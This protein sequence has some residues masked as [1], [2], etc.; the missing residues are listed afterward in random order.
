[1]IPIPEIGSDG[2]TSRIWVRD[3]LRWG[4]RWGLVTGAVIA[5]AALGI[6]GLKGFPDLGFPIPALIG[7]YLLAGGVGGM[8]VGLTRH[9]MTTPTR[10]SLLGVVI[11]VPV[12]MLLAPAALG[13]YAS[14]NG[15]EF[16]GILLSS[17]FLGWFGSRSWW[18]I[19]LG[20]S[21]PQAPTSVPVPPRRG[22]NRPRGR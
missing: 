4:A 14:W 19:F 15:E 5:L 3:R 6:L 8:L 18:H 22:R 21:V 17:L 12:M 13:P 11:A 16:G 2:V 1:M 10:A 20:E 9:L 7:L